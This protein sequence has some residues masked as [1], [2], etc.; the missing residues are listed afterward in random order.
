MRRSPDQLKLFD[1]ADRAFIVVR[2][3]IQKWA[4][5]CTLSRDL[6][7]ACRLSRSHCRQL[8]PLARHRR[9]PRIRAPRPLAPPLSPSVRTDSTN[10][11]HV[12]LLTDIRTVFDRYD[13]DQLRTK[14]ELIPTLARLEDSP[15]SEWT[16][17]DDT[18]GPHVLTQGD[19][20]RLLRPF[21]IRS[22][23]IWPPQRR[24]GTKSES[25]YYRRQFEAAWASYCQPSATPPQQANS[26][27]CRDR[28]PPHDRH[29]FEGL[30]PGG[31]HK[32]DLSGVPP[33]R[34]L[35]RTHPHGESQ[36]T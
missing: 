11:Q 14:A 5:R 24:Q 6:G 28:E 17:L 25:G 31:P 10:N 36:L 15:W 9:R 7:I 2:E 32:I 18:A 21:N 1:E 4:A 13:T 33:S 34:H 29:T 20:G 26:D 16:G 22:K 12:T 3:A 27:T 35:C 30:P 23:T 19:I 8:A